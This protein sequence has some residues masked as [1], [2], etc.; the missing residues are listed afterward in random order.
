ME[1]LD[2]TEENVVV[3]NCEKEGRTRVKNLKEIEIWRT[4]KKIKIKN[5]AEIDWISIKV[6]KYAE[7]TSRRRRMI[8]LTNSNKTQLI[9]FDNK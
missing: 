9:N 3:E 6:W 1:L 5:S 2:S 7:K 8:E 4:I